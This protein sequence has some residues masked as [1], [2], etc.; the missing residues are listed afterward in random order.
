[1]GYLMNLII[2]LMVGTIIGCLVVTLIDKMSLFCRLVLLIAVGCM[3][4]ILNE[5][6]NVV[7]TVIGAVVTVGYLALCQV[8]KD[9]EVK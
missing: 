3:T 7:I 2:S 8:T 9:K 1:M 4:Y 6:V 5:W